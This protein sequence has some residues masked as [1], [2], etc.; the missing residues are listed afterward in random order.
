MHGPFISA[1]TKSH[2]SLA[3]EQTRQGVWKREHDELGIDVTI[4]SADSLDSRLKI[5]QEAVII[6][7]FRHPNS[8]RVY[9]VVDDESVSWE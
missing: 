6:G 8:A 2:Y 3:T 7:Q 4:K 5:L 9:G 1:L